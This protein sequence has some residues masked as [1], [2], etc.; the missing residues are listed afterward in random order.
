MAQ[1]RQTET[2]RLNDGTSMELMR[3]PGL[4]D[5]TWVEVKRY[6]E[7]NPEL[8]R[9]LRKISKNPEAMRG[10]LQLQ[11]LAEHYHAKLEH[12]DAPAQERMKALEQDPELAP[13]FE[14]VRRNGLE[15]VMKHYQDEELMLRVSR[16]MGGVPTDV[17]PALRHTE[18]APQ[19]LHEAAKSGDLQAVQEFLGKQQPLD[20]QDYKGI[21]PLGY[22]IGANRVAVAKL[23]L[24][25]R[26]NPFAVDSSGNSALHYAAGY[27]R[28]ELLEHILKVGANVNQCNAQGQTP[29]AVA[30][31]NKQQH[32]IAVMQAHGGRV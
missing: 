7:E 9:S 27:G 17:Q 18:E 14:E 15:A 23:L 22:A 16:K 21:T 32:T 4:D 6:L 10:W 29:L 26:A 3:V 25:N 13:I 5:S 24:D 31:L 20:M 2:L 11:A 28:R 1:A 8:A 19:S 30:R 12:G